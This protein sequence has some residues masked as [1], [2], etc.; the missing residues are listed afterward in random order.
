M[1]AEAGRIQAE[2]RLLGEDLGRLDARVAALK[3]HF[4]QAGRDI[5]QILVS[6]GRIIRR[7]E[8]I[9]AVDLGEGQVAGEGPPDQKSAA[10]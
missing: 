10:L 6:T 3:N 1:R 8:R 4:G 5:D 7:G 9:E 2:V